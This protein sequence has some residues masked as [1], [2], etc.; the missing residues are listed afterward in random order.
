MAGTAKK[1]TTVKKPTKTAKKT[2]ASTVV[3]EKTVKAVKTKSAAE[4]KQKTEKKAVSEKP[5][6]SEV[7]GL[8]AT[9]VGVDGSAKGKMTLPAELFGET[10]NK[11]LIAQA[12][13]VY[14]ANQR[15]GGANT[16]TRGQVEGSTRK[17]YRQKGTG[18]ARHGS[19]RAHIFVGGGVAFGPVTHDFSLTM[20]TKMKRKALASAITSQ[21][22]AGNVVIVDGLETLEPKTK[23]MAK[24][25]TAVSGAETMLLVISEKAEFVTR[26]AR[27]I[28]GVD[29][30]PAHSVSTYD[31]LS[32]KKVVFMKDSIAT[33]KDNVVKTG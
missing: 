2:V 17:I 25:L 30:L 15:V 10:V 11:Q 5:I 32:H 1:A 7:H 3:K 26:T 4:V 9:V 24:A 29:I 18:K 27:N 13:R 28:Q 14:L 12:V 6:A 16:K 23:F 19:I 33:I 21:Y 20:P 22:Q 8:V 31:I